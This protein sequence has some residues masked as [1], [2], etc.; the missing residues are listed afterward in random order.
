MSHWVPD[1]FRQNEWAN[2][3]LIESCRALTDEQLDATVPG[4][5]GSIR[6]TLQ[7]IVS[8]EGGYAFRLGHEPS[9]RLMRDAPWPGFD[10]L[11]TMVRAA[12]DGLAAASIEAPDR[13]IRV[14]AADESFDVEAGV[15]LI[16]AFHHG[17]EHRSQIC[18]ILTSF[19]VVPPELSGWDWGVAVDRMR[20]V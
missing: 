13:V 18:A 4:T 16:Q 15:I 14:G 9:P 7:H 6:D 10:A 2:L 19:G 12:A 5:F 11:V 3:A 17:T 8:A 20:S 1:F